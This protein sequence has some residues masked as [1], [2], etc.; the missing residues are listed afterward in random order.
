[1]ATGESRVV[2]TRQGLGI[3]SS[4][5]DGE[6]L[7]SLN[8]KKP[9]RQPILA[10]PESICCFPVCI[11]ANVRPRA[12][13]P[14]TS[15]HE[16]G[17]RFRCRPNNLATKLRIKTTNCSES[18]IQGCTTNASERGHTLLPAWGYARHVGNLRIVRPNVRMPEIL[19]ALGRRERT[20]PPGGTRRLSPRGP[21][22]S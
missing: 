13:L 15:G 1:M 18:S 2:T 17:L 16:C 14:L 6:H 12:R 22:A 3:E 8:Q 5:E 21:G 11:G 19:A 10:R 9:F 7:G 20:V 4:Q